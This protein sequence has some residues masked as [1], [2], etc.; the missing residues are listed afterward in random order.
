MTTVGVVGGLSVDHLVTEGAGAR[1]NCLGGPALFAALGSHTVAGVEVRLCTEL[2][3]DEPRFTEQLAAVGVDLT[4]CTRTTA[5]SRL[6]I[7]N[8]PQGRRII[9]TAA[10]DGLEL[11]GGQEQPKDA[12]A[13][14]APSF[15]RGLAG[16][17]LSSPAS[18]LDPRLTPPV[19]AVDPHQVEAHSRGLEYWQEIADAATVLL[20]SRVQLASLHPDPETAAALLLA[21][22]GCPVIARL[23]V[24]GILVVEPGRTSA[25]RDP[26]VRVVDTIGAGD[27]S[28]AA[29]T[30][31]LARG[32]DLAT[33][34][35]FGTSAARLVLADWG[36]RGL[37]GGIR[38]DEP[39]SSITITNKE[40]KVVCHS[41]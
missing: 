17:L 31:A 30:A 29:I 4:H 34:A 32:E 16:L 3:D 14:P 37:T 20:P 33:A 26:E 35:A 41:H 19:T 11:V 39:F 27:A 28:A 36:H 7:L 2:P 21:A 6:W 23:D 13:S 24:D 10:P 8:S 25:V 1:F 9:G 12:T 15:F 22:T 38:L 18:G 5:A 40:N